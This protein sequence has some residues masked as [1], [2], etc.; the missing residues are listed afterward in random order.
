[1]YPTMLGLESFPSLSVAEF[2]KAC[3]TLV[4]RL[5]GSSLEVALK[6]EVRFLPGYRGAN[7][8]FIDDF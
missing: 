6:R 3:E 1:M 2:D 4:H 5:S 8:C 7:E